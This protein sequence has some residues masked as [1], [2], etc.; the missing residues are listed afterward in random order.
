VK[1]HDVITA[2]EAI[3]H[4]SVDGFIVAIYENERP[5]QGLAARLDFKIR[6]AI[7]TMVKS[8]AITGHTG[9][10]TYFPF[11]REDIDPMKPSYRFLFVGGGKNS[12]PGQRKALPE[13]SLEALK[14][15]VVKLGWKKIGLSASD[16]PENCEA[17][18]KSLSKAGKSEGVEVWITQ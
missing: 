14:E 1:S 2:E 17:I 7:S 5:I 3:A 8:G 9:E 6:G 16:L 18:Q 12:E 10:C 13:K 15:N 4:E 11:R